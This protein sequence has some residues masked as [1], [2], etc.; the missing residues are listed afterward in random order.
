VLTAAH[1]GYATNAHIVEID[2]ISYPAPEHLYHPAYQGWIDSLDP[3]AREHD[4]M[5]LFTTDTLPP[6]YM[7]NRFY[8]SSKAGVCT[9]LIAQ[10]WGDEGDPEAPNILRESSYL[11]TEERD[12]TLV[13]E[14]ATPGSVCYGDSGGPLY[15][16]IGSEVYLAGTTSTGVC[17]AGSIH[18]KTSAF[19]SWIRAGIR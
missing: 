14:Q 6:P 7:G 19:I 13:T 2:G 4:V 17:N 16:V 9:G 8:D 3:V 10:G 15:A 12:R 11:V 1:C 18:I 5:L